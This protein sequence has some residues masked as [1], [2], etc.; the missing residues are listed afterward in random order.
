MRGAERPAKVQWSHPFL[1]P[2]QPLSND[3]ARQ[4]F[5]DITSNAGTIEQMDQLLAFTDN[6]PLAVDLIA[7]LVDYE[8]FSNVLSH[9]RAEKTSLLSLGFDRESSVEASISLS[10]SSPRITSDSK[11][12]LSLLSILPNGLSEAEL[13]QGDFGI[14][15]ILSCKAALQ[16]TSLAYRDNKQRLVL[17]MPIREYVQQI[18]PP[19]PYHIQAIRKQFYT[20]L[21]LFEK[22]CGEPV[23]NQITSNLA[24]LEG[25]L[26]QGL[27]LHVATLADT[28]QCILSVNGFYRETGRD[29]F[30]LLDDILSILPQLCDSQ[31]ETMV[32][33]ELFLT[34]HY[35]KSVS[36]E[37]IAQAI[38]YLG[39]TND[40]VLSSKFYEA[41]GHYIFHR[42]T[43]VQRAEQFLSKALVMSV[44]CGD[45]DRQCSV[46]TRFGWF[47]WG[48]KDYSV[49]NT[50][51]TAAQKLSNSSSNLYQEAL[52]TQLGAS[53]SRIIGD[54]KQCAVQLN[55]AAELVHICGMS[56]GW[57]AYDI[58]VN[59]ANIHLEKSEYMEARKF[60][61][62][63]VE[64]T[65]VE[66]NFVA[67][68]AAHLNIGI[69]NTIIGE[70]EEDKYHNFKAAQE[71]YKRGTQVELV[72]MLQAL[73]EFGEKKF[74]SA[75]AKFQECLYLSWGRKP[76]SEQFC[77]EQLADITMWPDSG[78]QYKWPILYLLHAYKS[79]YK[80]GLHKALLF[81]GDAYIWNH[82][83]DTAANLYRVALDGFTQMDVHYNQAQCMLRLGD[84]ANKHGCTS[85]A[86]ALWK[87]AQ[88]LFKRS[89]A[90]DVSQIDFRLVNGEDACQKRML[91]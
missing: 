29:H 43:D 49:S 18:L 14:P 52:A 46:L 37:R 63:I 4:T 24:N 11:E 67:Y 64:N 82:D 31:L 48:T 19:S 23:I 51:A 2:L 16:G 65:S 71:I 3:A 69:I 59:Q 40:S 35:W 30:P 66:H 74:D 89:V 62:Q 27:H 15:N 6:M 68:A 70:A 17:L 13:V 75:K 88:P 81:L 8:G 34:R 61:C 54:Y 58:T 36:E 80:L 76:Q 21:E 60:F 9:W 72:S 55:R 22:C 28:I 83:D 39:H 5:M 79:Q 25:V 1:Q 84:L 47:K 85:E 45:K 7:H 57:L 53:C 87:A 20:I 44:L 91:L 90:K 56:G 32:L 41:A 26:Q 33:T 77:L 10:I 38:N 86:I 42:Q 12:L 78:S 50:Y 73:M